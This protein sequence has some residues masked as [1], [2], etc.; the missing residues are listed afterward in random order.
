MKLVSI[1]RQRQLIGVLLLSLALLIVLVYGLNQ[2]QSKQLRE[3]FVALQT[4]MSFVNNELHQNKNDKLKDEFTKHSEKSAEYSNV[5][6]SVGIAVNE[7]RTKLSL[8]KNTNYQT[9][10][11]AETNATK[12]EM[13]MQGSLSKIGD[14]HKADTQRICKEKYSK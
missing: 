2:H 4:V 1:K 12:I 7:E 8:G 3:Q 6:D 9:I 5:I 13:K 11:T 14:E 10:N